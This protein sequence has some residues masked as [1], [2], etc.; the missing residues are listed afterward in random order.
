MTNC[1]SEGT[2]DSGDSLIAISPIWDQSLIVILDI[3]DDLSGVHVDR[4][5]TNMQK[6]LDPMTRSITE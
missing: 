6:L 3:L 5:L 1:I 2:S 4:A